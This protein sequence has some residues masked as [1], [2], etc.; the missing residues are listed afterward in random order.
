LA[1]THTKKDIV[2]KIDFGAFVWPGLWCFL[3]ERV[4]DE[5]NDQEQ[6]IRARFDHIV[7]LIKMFGID[8]LPAKYTRHIEGRLWELRMK[9]KDGI[10][11]AL[12]V[13]TSG[14]RVVVHRVFAKKTQKTPRREIKL[15]LDRAREV[16]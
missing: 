2:Y 3:D 8:R 15:A 9:G 14:Q 11:R 7:Q 6:D 5:M 13:T 16:P 12:Y 4:E 1:L 10:A